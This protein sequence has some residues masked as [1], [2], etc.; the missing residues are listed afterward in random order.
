MDGKTFDKQ[1]AVILAPMSGVTDQPFRRLVRQLGGGLVVTEMIASREMIRAAQ[2]MMRSA[3]DISDEHPIAV[4]L[5]G[6]DPATMAE[7]ARLN[8]DRGAAII[9]INFGC[10]AKKVVNKLCGSALMRDERLASRIMAATVAA[11]PVPV[12]VKMRLGWDDDSRNAPQL[13][14][15]AEDAG[16]RRIAVHGRTRCQFYTG[17]ADWRFIRRVKDAVSIP[18][19]ANGDIRTYDDIDRCLAQSGADGV[20]IG[21]ATQGRPWFIAQALDYLKTGHRRPEPPPAER[22]LIA[23]AHLDALLGHY[24]AHKGIRIARKHLGWYA[25][26]LP[27]AARFREIINRTEE[28][29]VAHQALDDVFAMAADRLAA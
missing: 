26:G 5:A 16:V 22:R 6:D 23:L 27:G 4:Q 2:R 29:A 8:V 10:P 12:T 3:A 7:A 9:D 24:G 18:V 13:A 20:M 17:E 14:R 19:V 1:S 25:A 15:I 28:P 11:V 21:R